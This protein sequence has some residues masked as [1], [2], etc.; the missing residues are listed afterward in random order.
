LHQPFQGT[1]SLMIWG[2]Q[3]RLSS[4]P[5]RT[6]APGCINTRPSGGLKARICRTLSDMSEFIPSTSYCDQRQLRTTRLLL[7]YSLIQSWLA[8]NAGH[9]TRAAWVSDLK[10]PHIPLPPSASLPGQKT[11]KMRNKTSS[12]TNTHKDII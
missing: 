3:V 11:T 7:Y 10:L 5:K 2:F 4:L 9:T 8:R 1:H 12:M 6:P